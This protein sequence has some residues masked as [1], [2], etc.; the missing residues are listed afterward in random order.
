MEPVPG[1]EAFPVGASLAS[2]Y[3]EVDL[4]HVVRFSPVASQTSGLFIARIRKRKKPEG[5]Q[6]KQLNVKS[7]SMV[8]DD[9]RGATS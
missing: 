7:V 6:V 1:V 9:S 4:S 2:E 8:V 5:T 3:P